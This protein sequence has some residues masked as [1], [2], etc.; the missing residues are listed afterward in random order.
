MVS[1]VSERFIDGGVVSRLSHQQHA[2]ATA[3]PGH[4]LLQPRFAVR[5]YGGLRT[6]SIRWFPCHSCIDGGVASRLSIR[7]RHATDVASRISDAAAVI[8]NE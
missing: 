1:I 6:P 4:E 7:Q 5:I 8:T 2:I 3:N